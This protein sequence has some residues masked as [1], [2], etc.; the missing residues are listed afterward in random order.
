[1]NA[2]SL[3]LGRSLLATPLSEV[4]KLVSLVPTNDP[5]DPLD[6]LSDGVVHVADL[7]PP[8]PEPSARVDILRFKPWVHDRQ[9]SVSLQAGHGVGVLAIDNMSVDDVLGVAFGD[10]PS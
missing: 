5:I 7:V 3:R 6:S 2:F 1:M 9:G 8:R 4:R 10:H